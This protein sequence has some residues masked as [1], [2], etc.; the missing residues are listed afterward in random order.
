MSYFSEYGFHH[1][2]LWCLVWISLIIIDYIF[3]SDSESFWMSFSWK[4]RV[5]SL[6]T[7]SE[8][9]NLY[10]SMKIDLGFFFFCLFRSIIFQ[11]QIINQEKSSSRP[12][13]TIRYIVRLG[14][15]HSIYQ[16]TD[17][18]PTPKPCPKYLGI[19]PCP[20]IVEIIHLA[21]QRLTQPFCKK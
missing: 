9:M 2:S 19:S 12:W 17:V 14:W 15:E 8:T 16:S 11:V 21:S 4:L 18:Y 1:K 6:T 3:F 20:L 5:H 7:C 13:S 10:E